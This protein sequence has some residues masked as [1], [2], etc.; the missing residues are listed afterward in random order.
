MLVFA[1]SMLVLHSF[2]VDFQR[3]RRACNQVKRL[4]LCVWA[5]G[6]THLAD[7]QCVSAGLLK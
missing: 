2:Q 3:W 7:R 5:V 4:Q 1:P 6:C